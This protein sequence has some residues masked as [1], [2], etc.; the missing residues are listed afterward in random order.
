MPLFNRGLVGGVGPSVLLT[1]AP[2]LLAMTGLAPRT[3]FM[4]VL[5]TRLPLASLGFVT[6]V[7]AGADAPHA[8]TQKIANISLICP[9]LHSPFSIE[10]DVGDCTPKGR[11]RR[12]PGRVNRCPN[13]V[14]EQTRRGP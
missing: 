11:F 8:I 3:G 14:P 2:G 13:N 5:R 6:P 1:V 10:Q 12:V 4:P 7:C 9:R